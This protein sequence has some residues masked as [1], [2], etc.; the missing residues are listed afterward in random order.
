M[1]TPSKPTVW[2]AAFH[3]IDCRNVHVPIL[4]YLTDKPLLQSHI[5]VK[6]AGYAVPGLNW[7]ILFL[8]ALFYLSAQTC[9]CVCVLWTHAYRPGWLHWPRPFITH[10][11]R[12]IGNRHAR[13]WPYFA[14]QCSRAARLPS[15]EPALTGAANQRRT[16]F[17]NELK[18]E[19]NF[20][21]F[22]KVLR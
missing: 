21:L 18:K 10:R 7:A 3:N 8:Q 16:C 1:T 19:K 14:S 13:Q 11:L 9:V 12:S 4:Y 2:T 22:E 6:A 5:L 17:A 20:I 15:G